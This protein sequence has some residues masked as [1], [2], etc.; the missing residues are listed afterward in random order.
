MF[1]LLVPG[2]LS[3]SEVEPRSCS[4]CRRDEFPDVRRR[5]QFE[6]YSPRSVCDSVLESAAGKDIF[7]PRMTPK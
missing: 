5:L 4:E 1:S 7:T 3:A 6:S 2:T